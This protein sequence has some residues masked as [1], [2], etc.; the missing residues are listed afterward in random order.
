LTLLRH[1]NFC[2][3]LGAYYYNSSTRYLI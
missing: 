1:R 3:V 2:S